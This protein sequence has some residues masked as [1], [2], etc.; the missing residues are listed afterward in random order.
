MGHRSLEIALKMV[1]LITWRGQLRKHI[2]VRPPGLPK[3]RAHGAHQARLQTLVQ[4]IRKAS[5]SKLDPSQRLLRPCER[6]IEHCFPGLAPFV[7]LFLLLSLLRLLFLQSGEPCIPR[8][9]HLLLRE[10]SRCRRA[11]RAAE[12]DVSHPAGSRILMHL[13]SLGV[14][15]LQHE[16]PRGLVLFVGVRLM[17]CRLL[18]ADPGDEIAEA[19]RGDHVH[20]LE[21]L[22][23]LAQ[24]LLQQRHPLRGLPHR[25]CQLLRRW[26]RLTLLQ[27]LGEVQQAARR[28]SID[29][30]GRGNRSGG[31]LWSTCILGRLCLNGGSGGSWGKVAGVGTGGR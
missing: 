3:P 24:G 12:A 15:S 18:A 26:R 16:R 23:A 1:L 4:R 22:A 8:P 20:H 25:R 27:R 5:H 13:M 30:H 28:R 31:V 9:V 11:G 7:R 10:R 17:M 2:C 14:A 6:A 29:D 21:R 19:V